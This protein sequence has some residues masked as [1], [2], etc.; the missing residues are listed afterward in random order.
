SLSPSSSSPFSTSSI[1]RCLYRQPSANPSL[2]PLSSPSSPSPIPKS[3]N[4]KTLVS[5]NS[6]HHTSHAH[7]HSSNT[8]IDREAHT[9]ASV[10][11]Q[12]IMEYMRSNDAYRFCLNEFRTFSSNQ[13]LFF[14]TFD[15]GSSV[16]SVEEALADS[17]DLRNF[18]RRMLPGVLGERHSTPVI[19][20]S[21]REVGRFFSR[22]DL[23]SF[24]ESLSPEDR[25]VAAEIRSSNQIAARMIWDTTWSGLIRRYS[26]EIRSYR[27]PNQGTNFPLGLDYS[28]PSSPSSPSSSLGSSP[29]LSSS[30]PSL[31]PWPGPEGE[32]LSKSFKLCR[33]IWSGMDMHLQTIGNW[34]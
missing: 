29:R 11:I 20:P 14:A 4:T 25:A 22:P 7:S 31:L 27:S 8:N 19:L 2:S 23:D 24:L 32:R 34:K 17:S 6:A 28:P 9:F 5:R 12:R 26:D 3:S 1:A 13:Q 18:T 21:A 16:S 15:S 30:V 10:P 33:E